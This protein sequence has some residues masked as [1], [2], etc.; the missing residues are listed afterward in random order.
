MKDQA[1]F[2]SRFFWL[3]LPVLAII[4]Q[5][6]IEIFVSRE[7]KVILL[8]ENGW[9][10]IVQNIT[11]AIAF[12]IGLL[13]LPKL[14]WKDH[15]WLG[16]WIALATLCCL[17]VTGE[18]ISWGQH[19]LNWNTPE[20]WAKINDQNETNLHNTSDW[21]DQKPRLILLIGIIIG[22]L[23]IPALRRW[24][25]ERLPAKFS[26]IYPSNRMVVTALGVVLPYAS[27]KIWHLVTGGD[28]FER[29]SE[30]QELYMYYFVALYIFEL[31]KYRI[32]QL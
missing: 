25:P 27:Q 12:L 19:L 24:K 21:L 2:L 18:E 13:T 23:I 32:P 26:V 14:D 15:K 17:Y 20:Y 1:Y 29:V 8:S 30:V 16:L 28:L 11:I 22:G 10:E 9:H 31:R 3:W 5:I 4:V 6:L 7:E